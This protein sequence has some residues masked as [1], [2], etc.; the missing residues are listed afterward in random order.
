MLS[1]APEF[2]TKNHSVPKNDQSSCWVTMYRLKYQLMQFCITLFASQKYL[3]QPV[4]SVAFYFCCIPMQ[5]TLL[6]LKQ[7]ALSL[8]FKLAL[9]A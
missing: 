3:M 8:N 4:R 7:S 5:T 1:Q 6:I 2:I 9:S